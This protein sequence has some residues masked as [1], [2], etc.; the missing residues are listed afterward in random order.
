MILIHELLGYKNIKI[1]QDEEKFRFSLD[2]TLLANFVKTNKNTKKIIDLGTGNGP[3]PLF[4]SL[5][6][7][8]QIIGIEI[9]EEVYD[10]AK[11][12]IEIN[13]LE[14]QIEILN[15]NIIDV[16]KIVGN[17]CFDIVV[18]NPPYFPYS[19]TSN[20][21]KNDYLT[22]ARHEVLV[23]LDQ[24]VNE[25]R[26]LLVDG[27]ALYMVHRANRLSD[28]LISFNKHKFGLKRL[29]FI[30]PKTS[31]EEALIVLVEARFNKKSDS[32]VEKPMYIY[33]DNNEYTEEVSKIFNFKKDEYKNKE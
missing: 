27:G 25:A 26:K 12:S 20:I 1:Y 6:T 21:N 3:I 31:S 7:K 14:K 17:D 22:I 4:L 13:N 24:I 28:L 10:L 29:K 30:Y 23:T 18:S 8:A 5:K 33:D 32:V 19:P 15:K 9:Q 2:S 11:K 16:Y